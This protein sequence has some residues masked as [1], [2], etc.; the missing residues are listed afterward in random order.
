MYFINMLLQ[1]SDRM[2]TSPCLSVTQFIDVLNQTLEYAYPSI[3]IEGEVASFK[4]NQGKYVFFDLKDE[5]ASINCFMM[6]YQL[7]VGL[8]DGMKVRISAHAKM[9]A[10]GR[11]SLTVQSIRPVGEGSLKK[12]YELLLKKL[13]KEGLFDTSRKRILPEYIQTIGLVCSTESAGYADFIRIINER[14]SGLAVD[15][16]HVQVQGDVAPKQIVQ[17]LSHFNE[18]SVHPDVIVVIRGGGSADDLHAF[19][20]EEVVRAIASSRIPTVVAI[21][22]ETDE[23]L[24]ELV[25][26][27]RGA[28]PSHAATIVTQD[29][30]QVRLESQ[31]MLRSMLRHT[32][33]A[34]NLV[35]NEVKQECE[36]CLTQYSS[37]LEKNRHDM[38]MIMRLLTQYDPEKVLAKGYGLIRGEVEVGQDID[39][40]TKQS[41][42]QA[43]VEYVKQR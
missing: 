27:V 43:K 18:A 14:W 5:N 40:V 30:A 10:W 2:S 31:H 41:I 38:R 34:I 37:E 21:G 17:A 3:V 20:D 11:F 29:K 19:N 4:V 35:R 39:I 36:L 23:C 8:T 25:A 9:T 15:V 22:H 32:K 28:T 26:D 13:T 24:A 33:H 16:A 1:E 6:A 7:H 12:S 42:I